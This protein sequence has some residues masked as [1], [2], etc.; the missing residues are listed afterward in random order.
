MENHHFYIMGKSTISMAMFNSYVKL[1]EDNYGLITINSPFSYGFP[2]VF[3]QKYNKNIEKPTKWGLNVHSPSH[4]LL[5]G[6]TLVR[7][8]FFC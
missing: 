5:T 8:V 4:H 1:P 6:T 3:Q 2:R 7:N